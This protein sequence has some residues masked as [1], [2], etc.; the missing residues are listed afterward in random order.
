MP[1][2]V[3]PPRPAGLLL[4][5]FAS[6][7]DFEALAG[8][9]DEEFHQ[10]LRSSGP[11]AARRWYRREALRTAWALATRWR[12]LEVLV[13]T[14]LAIAVLRVAFLLFFVWLHAELVSAPRTA[15]LQALLLLVFE[16][17]VAMAVGA[18]T[19]R[20][21]SG[22]ET[23]LR[24]AFTVLYLAQWGYLAYRVDIRPPAP[25]LFLFVW[26]TL[27]IAGSFWVGSLATSRRR[28]RP[29]AA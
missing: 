22:R 24:L 23:M 15:G 11:Q 3:R 21:V 28:R 8:D 4:R 16:C 17:A 1:E 7:P 26:N 12:R 6:D 27:W 18:G 9:L 25:R 10:H 14:V 13:L 19:T 29:V 2:T 20:L 5:L